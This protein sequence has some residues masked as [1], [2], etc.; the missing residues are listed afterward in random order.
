MDNLLR[1]LEK[2]PAM[3]ET[4][5]QTQKKDKNE[6]KITLHIPAAT[7]KKKSSQQKIKVVSSGDFNFTEGYHDAVG[8]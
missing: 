8:F 6:T 7:V 2:H 3:I 4:L 5:T 1:I